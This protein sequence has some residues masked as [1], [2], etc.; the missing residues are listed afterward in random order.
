[1]ALFSR[2][3]RR[4]PRRRDATLRGITLRAIQGFSR[5]AGEFSGKAGP[6]APHRV[7]ARARRHL[8]GSPGCSRSSKPR[9]S[10]STRASL[11]TTTSC[12]DSG[13]LLSA[14]ARIEKP[15]GRAASGND[16]RSG[17]DLRRATERDHPRPE[18]RSA[19]RRAGARHRNGLRAPASGGAGVV[20]DRVKQ[21]ATSKRLLSEG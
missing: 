18:S 12:T 6:S 8:R 20:Q 17:N 14:R 10:S 21:K 5:R 1:M 9:A 19:G 13:R 11:Y 4:H 15:P 7:T 16:A 3:L 2:A